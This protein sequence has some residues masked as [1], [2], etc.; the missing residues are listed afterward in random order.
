MS[1][2]ALQPLPP[3][4]RVE[5]FRGWFG[6]YA[7]AREKFGPWILGLLGGASAVV[8]AWND[9]LP[10]TLHDLLGATISVGAIA[11][12]FLA[13]AKSMLLS[14]SKSRVVRELKNA[15]HF[16]RLTGYFMTAI[17]WSFLLA[18][19]SALGLLFDLD[20]NKQPHPWLFGLWVFTLVAASACCYRVINLF[21]MILMSPD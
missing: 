6:R 14:I 20:G 2:C 10:R 8:W 9:P 13:T 15:G 1:V 7:N 19:L 3:P 16:K 18:A 17:R 12:G 21:A 11:V 5:R 4:G